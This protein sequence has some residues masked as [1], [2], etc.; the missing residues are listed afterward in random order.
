MAIN[1][2]MGKIFYI[3]TVNSTCQEVS[4]EF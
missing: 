2:P 4:K 3:G 1:R